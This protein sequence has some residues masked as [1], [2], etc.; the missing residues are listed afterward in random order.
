MFSAS[1]PN[2]F[3]GADQAARGGYN[4]AQ[5]ADES[6]AQDLARQMGGKVVYTNTVGPGAPPSQAMIDFGG[7]NMHNAGLIADINKR[8]ADDEGMRKFALDN[9]RQE[10][11]SYGGDTGGFA[12]GG[13]VKFFS[14]S[15]AALA[16]PPLAY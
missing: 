2:N 5:Y 11:R 10:I 3:A 8:F 1:K 13:I 16:N 9:L 15:S 6:V 7:S 14:I 4:P 12:Q